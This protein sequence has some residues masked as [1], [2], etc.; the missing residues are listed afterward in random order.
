M[1]RGQQSTPLVFHD[2]I[3]SLDDDDADVTGMVCGEISRETGCYGIPSTVSGCA[4]NADAIHSGQT[5]R[6]IL[7]M[8]LSDQTL[9]QDFNPILG[10]DHFVLWFEC[11]ALCNG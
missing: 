7:T 2:H 5:D 10:E 11:A 6:G 9:L 8:D 3:G 4:C 1:R